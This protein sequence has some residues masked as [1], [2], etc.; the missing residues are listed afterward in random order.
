[1]SPWP[2]RRLCVGVD[3]GGLRIIALERARVLEESLV[4]GPLDPAQASRIGAQLSDR[5]AQVPFSRLAADIVLDDSL[6]RHFVVTRPR[7]VRDQADLDALIAARFEERF[8]LPGQDWQCAADCGVFDTTFL[9][10]AAP[11]WLIETLRQACAV[12]ASPIERMTSFLASEANR[13]RRRLPKEAHWFAACGR[14][15]VSLA[16]GNAA[17]WQGVAVAGLDDAPDALE[18][19]LERAAMRLGVVPATNIYCTGLSGAARRPEACNAL[20]VATWPG[21][22]ARW[23]RERRV[24]LSGVWP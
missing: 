7:G 10:C 15:Q 14:D 18:A 22:D 8:G 23:S 1:M 4:A 24:A 6:V 20:D 2:P 16:Y 5:L 21:Q 17:N 13:V 12:A 3:A 11:R 19:A 9:A